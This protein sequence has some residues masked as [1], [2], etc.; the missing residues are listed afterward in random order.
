MLSPSLR[1]GGDLPK[2][3]ADLVEDG[4]G[5]MEDFLVREAEQHDAV[6]SEERV[7][8]S[9]TSLAAAVRRAVELDRE[10]DRHAEE[11]GEVGPDGE[12]APELEAVELAPAK[13]LPEQ[14]LGGRGVVAMPAGQDGL[15][16]KSTIH[17]LDVDARVRELRGIDSRSGGLRIPP[18]EASIPNRAR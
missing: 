8:K 4:H 5:A 3:V 17:P 1:E 10:L 12:L 13:A 7:A 11:V 2:G 18:C 16:T 9:V 14:R 6:L 15:T